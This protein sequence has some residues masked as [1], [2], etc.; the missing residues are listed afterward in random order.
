MMC[1]NLACNLRLEADVLLVCGYGLG[2]R[3]QFEVVTEEARAIL[4]RLRDKINNMCLISLIIPFMPILLMLGA[5]WS[6]AIYT[7]CARKSSWHMPTRGWQPSIS[8][9]CAGCSARRT[10]SRPQRT[11]VGVEKS[12]AQAKGPQARHIRHGSSAARHAREQH[13]AVPGARPG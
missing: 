12:K 10:S 1:R 7:V 4:A 2:G 3:R 8:P 13:A 6:D 11:L 9:A 5:A